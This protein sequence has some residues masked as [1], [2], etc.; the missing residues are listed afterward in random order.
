MHIT[1]C[2][3]KSMYWHAVCIC[4]SHEMMHQLVLQEPSMLLKAQRACVQDAALHVR[5]VAA[6]R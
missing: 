5:P 3:D 4:Y 1:L 6:L 2:L